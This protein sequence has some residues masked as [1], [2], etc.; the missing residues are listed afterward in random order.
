MFKVKTNHLVILQEQNIDFY[1]YFIQL[2]NVTYNRR[3]HF[4]LIF[5]LFLNKIN[6]PYG[7]LCDQLSYFKGY[8]YIC[9]MLM[10][11]VPTN[12]KTLQVLNNQSKPIKTAIY[13]RLK[14]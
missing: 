7:E 6:H 13:D 1:V 8:T 9:K 3:I 4:I 10:N 12:I 14:V 2:N 5:N 11:Q